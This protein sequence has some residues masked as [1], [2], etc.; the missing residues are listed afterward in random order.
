MRKYRD[1]VSWANKATTRVADHIIEA[2]DAVSQ[3]SKFDTGENVLRRRCNTVRADLGYVWEN[4][5]PS[6][7]ASG[8]SATG[9]DSSKRRLL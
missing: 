8:A 1:D 3:Q 2:W 6:R 9:C 7:G 4:G 5:S